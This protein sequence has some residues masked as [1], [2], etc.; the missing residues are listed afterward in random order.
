MRGKDHGSDRSEDER[1][2]YG[3]LAC[4]AACR[5][6]LAVASDGTASDAEMRALR[7]RID[8]N[9]RSSHALAILACLYAPLKR[10]ASSLLELGA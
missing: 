4:S 9:R 7:T 10:E 5:N 2:T 6:L 3:R 1:A 8:A